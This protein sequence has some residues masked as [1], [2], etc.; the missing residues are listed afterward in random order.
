MVVPGETPE[1]ETCYE[2]VEFVD[3]YPTLADLCGLTGTPEDLEGISFRALLS[4]P[5]LPWK[6]A[7]YI[8]VKRGD[9]FGRAVHTQ[10]W[11]YVEW[12]EG[13]RGIEL[14]DHEIDP[15]EYFNLAGNPEYADQIAYLKDLLHNG[16]NRLRQVESTPVDSSSEGRSR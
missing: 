1:G 7:G 12:D 3:F 8:Q 14:Y 13:R 6:E 10:R 16:Q 9:I 5:A 15:S 4:D 11:R 2:V